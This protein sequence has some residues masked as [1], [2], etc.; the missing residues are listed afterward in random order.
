LAACT[1]THDLGRL[2]DP[3]TRQQ[4]DTLA[5]RPGTT[6]QV[7]PLPGAKTRLPAYR[8][9]ASAE[10]GLMLSAG[11]GQAALIPYSQIQY[12]S[13]FDHARGARDGAVALGLVGLAF[14]VA[15]G[16]LVSNIRSDCSDGCPQGPD[17]GDVVFRAGGLFALIGA[18]LG[19]A[20]GAAA[21]HQDEYVLRPR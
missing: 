17:A 10:N 12:L 18:A 19:G 8:V 20:I 6:A 16:V 13:T 2:G 5:A 3:G 11:S 14:G 21:G 9:T 15:L 4:I 1:T 7:T